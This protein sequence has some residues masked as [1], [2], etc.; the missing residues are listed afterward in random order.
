MAERVDQ[1]VDFPLE[2]PAFVLLSFLFVINSHP[3]VKS[4]K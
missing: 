2:F 1:F 3:K 4:P